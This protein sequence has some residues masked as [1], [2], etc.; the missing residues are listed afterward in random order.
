MGI[1]DLFRKKKETQDEA[2][3]NENED[4]EQST[5]RKEKRG[6]SCCH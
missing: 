6:G 3:S 1:L 4:S 5:V 2:E